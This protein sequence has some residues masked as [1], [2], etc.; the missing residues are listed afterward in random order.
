MNKTNKTLRSSGEGGRWLGKEINKIIIII[1]TYNYNFPFRGGLGQGGKKRDKKLCKQCYQI[2]VTLYFFQS[3]SIPP[4]IKRNKKLKNKTNNA[5]AI[6]TVMMQCPLI[7]NGS[8][9][10]CVICVV[11]YHE[12]ANDLPLPT[13]RHSCVNST[14][15]E[16]SLCVMQWCYDA[17]MCL[18]FSF[19]VFTV[20]SQGQRVVNI[21]QWVKV[22]FSQL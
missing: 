17:L 7:S 21:S 16:W 15:S 12:T 20:P 6:T 1:I 10:G 8:V 19:W 13:E 9:T 14:V 18:P 4:K 2:E 22:I 11:S 3:W 5:G